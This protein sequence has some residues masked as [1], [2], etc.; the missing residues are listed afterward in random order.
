[1][2]GRQVICT[3]DRRCF[4]DKI[5]NKYIQ[6]QMGGAMETDDLVPISQTSRVKKVKRSKS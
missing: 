6:N 5:P 4:L 2:K 3:E 1:M